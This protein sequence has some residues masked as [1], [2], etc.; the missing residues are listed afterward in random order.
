[1]GWAHFGLALWK[2]IVLGGPWDIPGPDSYPGS[3]MG[4]KVGLICH[5]LIK[6]SWSFGVDCADGEEKAAKLW[7]GQKQPHTRLNHFIQN[8][9]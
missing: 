7:V 9:V 6:E 4:F 5:A 2:S 3:I 1:M 8:A